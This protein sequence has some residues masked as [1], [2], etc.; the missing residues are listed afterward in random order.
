MKAIITKYLGPTNFR[1][2]RVKATD[3]DYN[4]VT[5]SWDNSLN[6]DENHKEAASALCNKMQWKG[7]LVMG[8]LKNCYVHVFVKR[9]Y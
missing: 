7:N 8:S 4:S 2:S 6:T 1:P 9:K 3:E 5:L